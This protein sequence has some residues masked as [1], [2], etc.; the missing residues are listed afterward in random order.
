MH[1]I[2]GGFRFVPPA[3]RRTLV[4]H[5]RL[6]ALL[7]ERFSRRIVIVVAPAGFGKTTLLSQAIDDNEGTT[8]AIDV[9]FSCASDD[10]AASTLSEGLCRAAGVEPQPTPEAAVGALAE[11]IWHRAPA[12]VAIVLDD[13][14]LIAP[15]SPGA[16]VIAA[17]LAALPRN[18]HVVLAGRTAPRCRS[19]GSM[20]PERSS[21]SA[22]RTCRSRR[23]S[24]PTS[25]RGGVCRTSSSRAPAAGR[26]WPS[27]RRPA[28]PA[29]MP[30]TCGRRCWTGSP[31]T[32]GVTSP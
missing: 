32:G 19:P 27:C 23:P 28:A 1:P 12:Q 6:V 22:R 24:W 11:S 10:D 7:R 17:V 29:P 2:D 9:W 25:R 15:G 31:Q 14:H 8:G 21:G 26:R 13:V 3:P 20:S 30:H 18:G 16:D 4:A 5:E